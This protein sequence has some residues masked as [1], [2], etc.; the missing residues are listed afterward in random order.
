MHTHPA[1]AAA[2]GQRQPAS[3]VT[4]EGHR[5]LRPDAAAAPA[6][7]RGR[8]RARGRRAAARGRGGARGAYAGQRAAARARRACHAPR[9]RSGLR[10]RATHARR[11]RGRRPPAKRACS[12]GRLQLRRRGGHAPS[13]ERVAERAVG[14]AAR[15]QQRVQGQQV[16]WEGGRVWRCARQPPCYRRRV[17]TRPSLRGRAGARGAGRLC[18]AH[19]PRARPPAAAAGRR[20]R[21]PPPRRRRPPLMTAAQPAPPPPRRRA[22]AARP[23]PGS[24]KRLRAGRA[25][26]AA[27]AARRPGSPCVRVGRR[28]CGV[29]AYAFD[30]CNLAVSAHVHAPVAQQPAP[31]ARRQPLD[32]QQQRQYEPP[33]P[34]APRRAAA[35]AGPGEAQEAGELGAGARVQAARE[36]QPRDGALPGGARR[37][38]GGRHAVGCVTL[39][40]AMGQASALIARGTLPGPCLAPGAPAGPATR[41]GRRPCPRHPRSAQ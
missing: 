26:P 18:T 41:R 5:L 40:V 37:A 32:A 27:A 24:C 9:A 8:R 36:Q 3:G 33:L 13:V 34:R 12:A 30:K 10:A 7:G 25:P 1:A 11:G 22:A 15:R 6:A 28:T 23:R 29:S 19:L 39:A 35:R 16:A 14:H 38:R 21:R 20:G 31:Q 4:P 2:A 17:D